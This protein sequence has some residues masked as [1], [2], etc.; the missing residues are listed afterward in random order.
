MAQYFE[1]SFNPKNFEMGDR[2]KICKKLA[3][4]AETTINF[5]NAVV[6][7]CKKVIEEETYGSGFHGD[8]GNDPD[9]TPKN[10]KALK[11]SHDI[12]SQLVVPMFKTMENNKFFQVDN[13]DELIKTLVE[14]SSKILF[15]KG[16]FDG[17]TQ[18]LKALGNKTILT[19]IKVI[20]HECGNYPWCNC[21]E[22]ENEDSKTE[23]EISPLPQEEIRES[24]VRAFM[25]ACEFIR[26]L[27]GQ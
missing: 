2:V 18:K 13:W 27:M 22:T 26:Y 19:V 23:P 12:F 14:N 21:G 3:S 11:T 17:D 24:D 20:P 15:P 8:G 7:Y 1:F 9:N 25:A 6:C 4:E 10:S 16:F 5:M